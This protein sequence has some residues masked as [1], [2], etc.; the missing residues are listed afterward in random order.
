MVARLQGR[1]F[2]QLQLATRRQSPKRI[3]GDLYGIPSIDRNGV[4]TIRLCSPCLFERGSDEVVG[5]LFCRQFLELAESSTLE[6]SG[7]FLRDT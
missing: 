7:T 3:S 5:V 4:F 2:D 6:L 1:C